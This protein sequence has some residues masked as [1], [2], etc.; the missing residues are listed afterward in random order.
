[1][2]KD[3]MFV[4][5]EPPSCALLERM[6]EF[7]I[8]RAAKQMDLEVSGTFRERAPGETGYPIKDCLSAGTAKE[9]V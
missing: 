9:V 2:A 6:A 3:V 4:V 1:M 8:K 7:L 5:Q